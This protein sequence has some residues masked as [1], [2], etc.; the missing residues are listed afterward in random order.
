MEFRMPRKG[1]NITINQWFYHLIK[2]LLRIWLQR[3]FNLKAII[4]EEIHSLKPP[5]LVLPN[6][7]GFWDPFMAGIYLKQQI[8]YIASDA[9]FRS[10]FFGL[11]MTLLGVIPKTKAQSDI[12]ALK[13]IIA[14][15]DRGDVIGI[16]PEG[17][18][19]WDG[20]TLPLVYSTSK[21]VRMLK[22]PVISVVFKGGYFSQPRWGV[23][24]QKGRILMEYKI[25]FSGAEIKTLK[26]SEIHKR[27]VD[28]LDFDEFKYQKE[29]SVEYKGKKSAEYLEQVLFFCPSCKGISTMFSKGNNFCCTDCNYDVVYNSFCNFESSKNNVIFDNIRDWNRWQQDILYN[30]LNRTIFNEKVIM[31]DSNLVFYTGYRSNKLKHFTNGFLILINNDNNKILNILN[32]KNEVLISIPLSEIGGLNIQNKERL[33][34]YYNSVLYSIKGKSKRFSAYKWLKSVEYILKD[35]TSQFQS[36]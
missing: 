24:V 14:I 35:S 34:F 30:Y 12:D 19:T 20:V 7:Q 9:I 8:F 17:R 33:E 22:V 32:S 18:R 31:E 10:P 28:A 27:L 1:T 25:L 36:G 15:K 11:L 13:N 4:P 2:P 29:V 3:Q 21:L 23:H 16:F 6:H 5:F 26:V